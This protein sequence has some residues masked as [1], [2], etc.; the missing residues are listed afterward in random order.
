MLEQQANYACSSA[1]SSISSMAFSD[2]T[3]HRPSA[4]RAPKCSIRWTVGRSA[5][6]EGEMHQAFL[7]VRTGRAR[8]SR[9]PRAP[10]RPPTARARLRPWRGRRL[11]KPHHYP[12]VCRAVIPS[13]CDLR[14]L[15]VGDEAALEAVARAF[16]VGQQ[17]G[18]HSAGAAFRR[19][20]RQVAN[21]TA[22]ASAAPP[23]RPDDREEQARAFRSTA[24]SLL[25]RQLRCGPGA[26]AALPR[27]AAD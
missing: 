24:L 12:R 22:A 14:F 6:S 4:R 27:S 8:Q 7:V 9:S 19:R 5:P 16:D 2:F 23:A 26:G 11:R 25:G 15:R 10:C 20:D 3:R 18:Q 21:R 17:R 1:F 13:S